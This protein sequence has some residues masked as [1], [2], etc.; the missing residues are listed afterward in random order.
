MK[1]LEPTRRV[2][3]GE[4]IGLDH[5]K[6]LTSG[7]G[8]VGSWRFDEGSGTTAGDSAG[9]AQD[10]TLRGNAAWSTELHP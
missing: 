4:E 3:T 10:A 8:L 5:R 2:R 7:P 1:A 6:V 9:T